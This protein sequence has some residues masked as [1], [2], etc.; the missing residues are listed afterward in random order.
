MDHSQQKRDHTI[1]SRMVKNWNNVVKLSEEY[2][3]RGN[4]RL[5]KVM[6]VLAAGRFF[7]SSNIVLP[8][9]DGP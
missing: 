7:L 2:L 6:E 4:Q 5:N 8:V 9:G 1:L 3:K